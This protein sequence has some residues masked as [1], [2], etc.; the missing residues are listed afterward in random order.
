M[1][2]HFEFKSEGFEQHTCNGRREGEWLIFECPECG[3][4]RKWN[5][6]TNEMKVTNE[7]NLNALHKGMFQPVGLQMETYNPN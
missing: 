2:K 7:G 6:K 5:Q 4:V 3:F 1:S